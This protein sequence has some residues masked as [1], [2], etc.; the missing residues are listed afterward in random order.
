MLLLLLFPDVR[1][2]SVF[3]VSSVDSA[4]LSEDVTELSFCS[5]RAVF[6]ITEVSSEDLFALA[7]FSSD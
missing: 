4:V 1:A 6:C 2:P 3:P 5:E 7:Y